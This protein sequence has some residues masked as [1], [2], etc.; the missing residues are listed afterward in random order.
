MRKPNPALKWEFLPDVLTIGDAATILNMSNESIRLA[1]VKGDIP[2][3]KIGGTT[4]RIG[5]AKLQAMFEGADTD[6]R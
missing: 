3:V 4:W 2:A 1:C 6:E 5:K